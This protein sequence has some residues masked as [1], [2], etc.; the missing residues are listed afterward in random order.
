[1]T[2]G[3]PPI[4]PSHAG[5]IRAEPKNAEEAYRE[6]VQ[7][8]RAQSTEQAIPLLTRAIQE[9]PDWEA[10]YSARAQAN[11]NMKRY[12]EAVDDLTVAIR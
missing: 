4:T 12:H 9:K 8:T 5:E 1:L 3:Y 11:Y 2:Y 7:L 6:G 10:A